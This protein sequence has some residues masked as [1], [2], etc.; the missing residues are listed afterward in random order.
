MDFSGDFFQSYMVMLYMIYIYKIN[1]N[2][3]ICILVLLT[4]SVLFSNAYIQ[5]NHEQ[6]TPKFWYSTK[7]D[8]NHKS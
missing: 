4:Q 7:H 1:T 2:N 8:N 3:L 5:D 6:H